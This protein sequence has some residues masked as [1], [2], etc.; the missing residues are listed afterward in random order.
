MTDSAGKP[1]FLVAE[2]A[3]PRSAALIFEIFLKFLVGHQLWRVVSFFR[4]NLV[5]SGI[6]LMTKNSSKPG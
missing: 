2:G 4:R 3:A 5:R 1:P 6:G